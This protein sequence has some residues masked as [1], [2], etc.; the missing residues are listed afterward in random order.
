ML[1]FSAVVFGLVGLVV[2]ADAF[3][4]GAASGARLLRVPPIV[5]GMV[6][7][8]FGTSAPELAVS[9][10]G[11]LAGNPG[12][13]LGNAYG[14][15]VCNVALILGLCALVRPVAVRRKS[16]RSDL[17]AL[18]AVTAVSEAF[19]VLP[20]PEPGLGRIESA[21][22]LV[23]FFW[24][25]ASMARRGDETDAA[26]PAEVPAPGAPGRAKALAAA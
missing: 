8:G 19:L 18:L 16:L 22:L 11:A 24:A 13:A 20:F 5:V 3:V 6:V 14:S 1:I 7:V 12:I 4:A 2:G 15:N 9:A 25:L 26:A 10:T 23:L 17:P 21:V